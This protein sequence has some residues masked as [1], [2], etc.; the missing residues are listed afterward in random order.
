MRR[1]A[2]D[3]VAHPGA[4]RQDRAITNRPDLGAE[5]APR[6]RLTVGG[7]CAGVAGVNTNAA[8]A[9]ARAI[10]IHIR[11]PLYLS[12]N[13]SALMTAPSQESAELTYRAPPRLLVSSPDKARAAVT[14]GILP[15]IAI[16]LLVIGL[17]M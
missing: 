9:V 14:Q 7:T 6:H 12:Y 1:D 15:L 13:C 2:D 17:A 5:K 3:P 10:F 8:T 4:I 16:V 11:Y